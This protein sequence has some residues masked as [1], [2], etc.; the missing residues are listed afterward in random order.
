VTLRRLCLTIALVLASAPLLARSAPVA[1]ARISG[2]APQSSATDPSGP[3]ETAVTAQEAGDGRPRVRLARYPRPHSPGEPWSQWGEGLVL[4]DGRFVS[5]IG[6]ERGADGNSF[7]FV[8]DPATDRI[9]RTDD[10]LSHVE[11]DAGDWGYGKVHGRIVPGRCGD[12]YFMTYWGS[13][14]GLE[15]RGTY[16]GDVM[17]RFDPR[18]STV[19]ALGVPIPE[20]GTPSLASLGA[21]GLIYGEATD[22]D[23]RAPRDHDTGAFFVY[24][25]RRNAVVFR[26][27]D[28]EHSLFRNIMLDADSRAYVAREGGRLL[29]YEPGSDRLRDAGVTLPG[30][31]PLRA[32]TR[33]APD[34]TVYGVT[35]SPGDDAPE[36][37]F[38]LTPDGTIRSLGEARGYTTSMAL[39]ARGTRFYYVPGAHGDSGEQG[40]P[41]IEV[42]TATG[43]QRVVAKLDPLSKATLGL[44]LAGSYNVALD[45]AR[46][47]LFVGLNAGTT[48]ADPWGEVGLAIV[49]LPT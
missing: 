4:R 13:R 3:H 42:D 46:N 45:A 48:D 6:D 30:G 31:G 29:V 24:D 7:V 19:E 36:Q 23:P 18:T 28:P 43:E 38:A 37:F 15:Y 5:A 33:P 39:S 41:V 49:D 8:Y 44:A 32:S 35:Q 25:T 11:H 2:C 22:P 1:G 12:A 27:D 21:N 20:H 47:R 40:T 17:F 9:T 26:D 16:H 10:V 14:R 34:G